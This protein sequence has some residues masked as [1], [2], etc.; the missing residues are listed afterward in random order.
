MESDLE[1]AQKSWLLMGVENCNRDT[2]RTVETG[3]Y[4]VETRNR[5]Y[6]EIYLDQQFGIGNTFCPWNFEVLES[7]CMEFIPCVFW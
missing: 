4:L 5:K 3:E 7:L 1:T 2:K 6:Q